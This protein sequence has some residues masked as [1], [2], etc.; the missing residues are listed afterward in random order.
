M[1]HINK[2]TQKVSLLSSEYNNR[3]ME[4]QKNNISSKKESCIPISNSKHTQLININLKPKLS[5]LQES[6]HISELLKT[7]KPE[8]QSNLPIDI[9]KDILTNNNYK[10]T[11]KESITSFVNSKSLNTKTY[12][13]TYTFSKYEPWNHLAN[14]SQKEDFNT[15]A[16]FENHQYRKKNHNYS[17]IS[18]HSPCETLS[19]SMSSEINSPPT[20]DFNF[21]QMSTFWPSDFYLHNGDKKQYSYVPNTLKQHSRSLSNEDI[22]SFQHIIPNKNNS[23]I[24]TSYEHLQESPA[25]HFLSLFSTTP[26]NIYP[27]EE[28]QQIGKYIIGKPIAHGSYSIVKEAITI[29]NGHK[30]VHA[31]KIVRK[32]ING[33]N[34]IVQAEIEKELE[35]WKLLDHPH[36]LPLF[37]IED[38][39]FA[40][41]CFTI[42]FSGGT[43]Y[44]I[45]K[46]EKGYGLS[47]SEAKK[48]S[49]QLASALRYLHQDIHLV[50]LDVKLENCLLDT[51][52]LENN[53]LLLCDFG[54]AEFISS[55]VIDNTHNSTSNNNSKLISTTTRGSLPY[56][57]PEIISSGKTIK[58]ASSDIWSY[59][60]L[61]HALIT[62]TLPFTHMYSPLLQMQILKGDWDI[63][64]LKKIAH[65]DSF[66]LILGCLQ[67]N[68]K[69]RWTIENILNS[70]W[71]QSYHY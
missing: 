61:L 67:P 44:D 5:S 37:S 22:H 68:P 13:L 18:E 43:L 12:P 11:P 17:Y 53:R 46:K 23:A 65:Q 60:I 36:I 41:F 48:Y 8:E 16:E 4:K 51:S 49:Y 24:S 62:G 31:V 6:T 32:N 19:I 54:M 14:I 38:T 40:T 71:F 9:S 7:T 2:I 3:N 20:Y 56:V 27:D 47:N 63:E 42:K 58:E 45:L 1:E 39:Q 34:D 50:H 69:K 35:I 59:G 15:L 29:E 21:F 70:K 64:T 28:G 66:D 25:S 30:N 52:E 57:S 55:T 26:P 33:K 10:Q